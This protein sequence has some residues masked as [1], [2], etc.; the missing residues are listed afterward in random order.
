MYAAGE[1]LF[2]L[3]I[4]P[5]PELVKIKKESC[6]LDQLY[7]LYM[8]VLQTLERSAIP[9]Y[10]LMHAC[11]V[12]CRCILRRTHA[13]YCRGTPCWRFLPLVNIPTLGFPKKRYCSGET[14]CVVP[15][16]WPS[17]FD[18]SKGSHALAVRFVPLDFSTALGVLQASAGGD[19]LEAIA[20]VWP[21]V[22]YT[23][24]SKQ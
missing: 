18:H 21:E 2:A 8:D 19:R 3:K 20:E 4:T 13:C 1:E 23:A 17:S 22:S 10:T 24:L 16:P 14:A 11:F 12:S 7:G 15:M 9:V 6:L 5:H